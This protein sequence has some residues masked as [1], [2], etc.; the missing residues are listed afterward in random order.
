[1]TVGTVV[2]LESAGNIWKNNRKITKISA[3]FQPT[4]SATAAVGSTVTTK[5]RAVDAGVMRP[6]SQLK[7]RVVKSLA[8]IS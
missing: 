2:A 4:T 7:P 1:M 3:V 8:L 5:T 6:G